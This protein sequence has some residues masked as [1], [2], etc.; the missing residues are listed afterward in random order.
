MVRWTAIWMLAV[1][2]TAG[3][4]PP[5]GAQTG[6]GADERYG[7]LVEELAW[8]GLT[9][10]T[11]AG[12]AGL[13]TAAIEEVVGGWLE[14]ETDPARCRAVLGGIEM[15]HGP[16]L[17]PLFARFLHRVTD[18]AIR[19]G[20]LETCLRVAPGRARDFLRAELE[21]GM[22]DRAGVI[23]LLARFADA[24]AVAAIKPWLADPVVGPAAAASLGATGRREAIPELIAI[25]KNP[26][27][28]SHK[29]AAA[30]ALEQ[31]AG[32]AFGPRAVVWS[33][34]WRQQGPDFE[35][36]RAIHDF[37][38]VAA[39]AD[40]APTPPGVFRS[41]ADAAAALPAAAVPAGLPAG[42][43]LADIINRP[44]A[45]R[46]VLF[47]VTGVAECIVPVSGEGWTIVALDLE[48]YPRV[49]MIIPA[50]AP[51][52]AAG[53]RASFRAVFYKLAGE[54][55]EPQPAVVFIGRPVDGG[56][57]ADTEDGTAR[58]IAELA[59]ISP[60]ARSAAR[61]RLTESGATAL[62]AL[63]QAVRGAADPVVRATVLLIIADIAGEEAV[64]LLE[65]HLA[66]D[67]PLMTACA[68]LALD[69][70][71]ERAAARRRSAPPP[72]AAVPVTGV[73]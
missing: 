35:V 33:E 36:R 45:W 72:P 21:S 31:I 43:R 59:G 20:V 24:A 7:R 12:I 25:L 6:E 4:V 44:A 29:A 61:K 53:T 42:P 14:V 22:A 17:V 30:A 3:L 65:E 48:V 60:D 9:A 46:G 8:E 18:P 10:R 26:P 56:A 62:P 50:T 15:V 52:P 1:L 5:A 70:V 39:I 13:G 69:Q 40:R 47:T 67:D 16:A 28:A 11:A 71:L 68:R 23:D 19:L 2:A 57:A 58:A 27:G 34:W 41:F 63:K 64:P 66:G 38:T 73:E 54:P 37:R 55:D 49:Q 51:M 32:F